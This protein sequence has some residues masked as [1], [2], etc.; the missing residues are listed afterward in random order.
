MPWDGFR[1]KYNGHSAHKWFIVHDSKSMK[2]HVVLTNSEFPLSLRVLASPA[3]LMCSSSSL[4]KEEGVF[5]HKDK[6]KSKFVNL[7]PLSSRTLTERKLQRVKGRTLLEFLGA[8]VGVDLS[9]AGNSGK[10]KRTTVGWAGADVR[11]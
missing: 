5:Y 1:N 7:Q 9:S 3:Q 8:G 4:Q 2:F 10:K 11:S 6:I